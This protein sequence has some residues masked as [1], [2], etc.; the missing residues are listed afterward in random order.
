MTAAVL[1][2]PQLAA[3]GTTRSVVSSA[4]LD[5]RANKDRVRL[6]SEGEFAG[7]V[8]LRSGHGEAFLQ[9]LGMQKAS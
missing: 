9:Q 1:W 2:V 5:Q 6:Y 3:D 4:L 8:L 7:E